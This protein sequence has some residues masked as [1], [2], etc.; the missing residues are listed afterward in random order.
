MVA[1]LKVCE[2]SSTS[3]PIKRYGATF[4]KPVFPVLNTTT[5]LA[6]LIGPDFWCIFNLLN[7]DASFFDEPV[8][9]WN[10]SKTYRTS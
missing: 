6:S 7:I 4:G 9:E 10:T 2:H 3:F 8:E 1:S 5:T